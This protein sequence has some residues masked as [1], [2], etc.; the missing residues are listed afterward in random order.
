MKN[1]CFLVFSLLAY[2]IL[3][4]SPGGVTSGLQFWLSAD[5]VTPGALVN[6]TGWQGRA[7]LPNFT[8]VNSNPQAISNAVNFNQMIEFDGSN[9]GMGGNGD[10]VANNSNLATGDTEGEIFIV[11]KQAQ[12]G[13]FTNHPFTFSNKSGSRNR[14]TNNGVIQ[15]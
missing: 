4:Q 13:N 5:D 11:L 14:Y 9:D 3:A 15:V 8:R 12:I 2:S 1:V 10:L 6:G 7:G